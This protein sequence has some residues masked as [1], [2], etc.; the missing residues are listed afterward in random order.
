LRPLIKSL[1]RLLMQKSG[2]RPDRDDVRASTTWKHA[3]LPAALVATL[4]VGPQDRTDTDAI[5]TPARHSSF[6]AL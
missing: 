6:Y 2:E 3:P 1:P 5:S 4:A